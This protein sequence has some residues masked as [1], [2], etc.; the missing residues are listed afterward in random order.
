MQRKS[1][2]I[3][4]PVYY[5]TFE[6]VFAGKER[7]RGIWHRGDLYYA[8]LNASTNGKQYKYP[9]LGATTIPQA[10]TEVQVLK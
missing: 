1:K 9:S 7:I 4:P 3:T 6:K 5:Y 2:L 8:Q 10:L